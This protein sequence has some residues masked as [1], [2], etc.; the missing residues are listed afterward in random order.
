MDTEVN[1]L[2][3]MLVELSR[4]QYSERC[5]MSVYS[6]TIVKSDKTNKIDKVRTSRHISINFFRLINNIDV[7]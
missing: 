7:K 5:F 6:K 4:F 1:P 3:S 2:S